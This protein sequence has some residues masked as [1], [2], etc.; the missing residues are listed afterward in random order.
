[1]AAIGRPPKPLALKI[2]EGNPGHRPLNRYEPKPRP[3]APPCPR[4]LEPEA[5]RE[6]KRI[7]RE[8]EALGLL[9]V[10]D[11]AVLAGYCQAWARWRAAEEVLTREGTTFTTP[12]GYRQQ[13]PEVSI[14]QKSLQLVAKFATEFGLT[15]SARTRLGVHYVGEKDEDDP[16]DL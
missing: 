9:T 2:L 1:M 11:R 15:P 16:F 4:W 13:R 10:I 12:N 8:L 7:S 5:K 6:W 3:I 14:A